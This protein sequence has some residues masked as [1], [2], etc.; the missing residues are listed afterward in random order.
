M[1]KLFINGLMVVTSLVLT[2]G[3]VF[4]MQPQAVS[5]KETAP[6]KQLNNVEEKPTAPAQEQPTEAPA[7]EP[8]A[9]PAQTA[10]A[11]VSAP[12][13]APDGSHDDWMRQAGI[14]EEDL[15]YARFIVDHENGKWCANRSFGQAECGAGIVT[16]AYG[17]CQALP[18]TKMA[19]AG[20]DW[21]TNII[22]Q[23]RWCDGYAKSRYG[24]WS[25]AYYHWINNGNW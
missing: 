3:L 5:Q 7:P 20:D 19:T 12:D 15:N 10:P 21:A 14:A 9:Q 17:A 24:S 25:A 4:A 1:R 18:G 6:K 2:G 11:P 13:T 16:M 22:T 23:L 8:T